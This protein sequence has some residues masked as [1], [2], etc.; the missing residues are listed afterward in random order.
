MLLIGE[1]ARAGKSLFEHSA[2]T[3]LK[4]LGALKTNLLVTEWLKLTQESY[5][6]NP[7]GKLLCRMRGL[8]FN[9]YWEPTR[10]QDSRITLDV[11]YEAERF[12]TQG[13]ED[14]E[15]GADDIANA[16]KEG[17]KRIDTWFEECINELRAE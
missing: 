4:M 1:A 9:Y 10:E 6:Q 3:S 2:G 17:V 15:Q 5:M 13:W 16:L 12:K 7:V 14:L 8:L 11:A